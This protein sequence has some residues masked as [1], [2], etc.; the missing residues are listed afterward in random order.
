MELGCQ[1]AS[2]LLAHLEQTTIS[3]AFMGELVPQAPEE[4]LL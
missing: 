4:K 1:K 3:K 2:K